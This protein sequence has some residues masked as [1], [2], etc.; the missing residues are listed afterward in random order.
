MYPG[1]FYFEES[2]FKLIDDDK[3]N[4][5]EKFVV[6]LDTRIPQDTQNNETEENAGKIS[7]K[8]RAID[9][10]E[11]TLEY[12]LFTKRDSKWKPIYGIYKIGLYSQTDDQVFDLNKLTEQK[13]DYYTK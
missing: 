3:V 5:G 10:T 1:K 9:G 8:Y 7:F 11:K 13:Y 4:T 2:S 12:D 6:V